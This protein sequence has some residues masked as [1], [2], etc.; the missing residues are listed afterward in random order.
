MS[1]EK[2]KRDAFVY[3]APK[4]RDKKPQDFAQCISCRKFV[5]HVDGLKGSRC[6]EHG[7]KVVVDE[8]YSCGFWDDWA[9]PDGKP[10]A[11]VVANHA[12]ELANIVPG[13]VTPEESGLVDRQ[14]RCE[15][16][17]FFGAKHKHCHLYKGLNES[18]PEVFDLDINVEPDACCNAQTEMDDD[19]DQGSDEVFSNALADA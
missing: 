5:P 14:V 13:S 7:S 12:A 2:I 1:F 19:G 4:P 11:E 9:T 18:L 10:N 15:N 8:G 17:E 3:L 16:C 6:A